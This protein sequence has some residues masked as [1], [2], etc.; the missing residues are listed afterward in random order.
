MTAF[1][2]ISTNAPI[3]VSRPIEQPYRLTRSGWK[4]RTP[5][6][7]VTLSET[8]TVRSSLMRKVGRGGMCG[9]SAG[10]SSRP[11][12][13]RDDSSLAPRW[14]PLQIRAR[15]LATCI[16]AL[17][18][19][20]K[21]TLRSA[22]SALHN[23]MVPHTIELASSTRRA[24]SPTG[25][26]TTPDFIRRESPR[27][28]SQRAGLVFACCLT[29][30][31]WPALALAQNAIVTEN[32]LTGNPSSQWDISGSGDS[33]IQG[34]A[35]DISVNKGGVIH[36]KIKTTAGAY[37]IDIYRLGYYQGNG[38]RLVGSGVITASLPQTQPPDLYD[39]STGLT[40]CGNWS[41]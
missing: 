21:G 17:P 28:R 12:G 33:S 4:I 39:S 7:R 23:S 40:D 26:V 34:F 27:A 31:A 16:A 8:G 1:F 6:A 20:S 32:A 41:E 22:R 15:F 9:A 29:A 3:L 14:G 25:L 13:V 18:I 11:G 5:S 37:H 38:A 19:G 35:T 2:W 10:G 36:F 30:L 24:P